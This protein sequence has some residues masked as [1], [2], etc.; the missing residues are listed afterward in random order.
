MRVLVIRHAHA[1]QQSPGMPDAER[2]LT[3]EG[4]RGFSAAARGLARL[5]RPDVLL[6]S[7]LRRAR[8]TAAAAAWGAIAAT[9][10][11]A[12]ASRDVAA[13]LDALE[14][15]PL[16]ATV[17]MVGHEPTVSALVSQLASASP[18]TTSSQPLTFTPGAAALLEVSSIVRRSGRLLWFYPAT[19]AAAL[20]GVG[21]SG[22]LSPTKD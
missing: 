2:P 4:A 14:I 11:P 19:A 3:A 18:E 9:P 20:G 7:P 22:A 1:A 16:D 10:E 13:I 21:G 6:T 15:H 8:Q 17:A 5:V 12:L